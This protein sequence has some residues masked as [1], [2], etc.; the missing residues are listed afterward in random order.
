MKIKINK[1]LN[2]SYDERPKIIAEISGNHGGSKKR[3]LQLIKSAALNG[4]DLIKIQ[5]YEPEDITLKSKT[6]QFYLKDGIWKGQHLWSLYENSCTPFSWHKDAFKLAKK[7]KVELF[8]SPFSIRGVDLLEKY[9]CKIYKIASFEITDL[10]LVNYIASKKKPIIMSTGMASSVEIKNAINT[11]KK[12]HNKIIILHCVSLYPTRL[13]QINLNR[14]NK[15]K[16]LY[17]KC[18]I[19]LSDHTNSI[20]SSLVSVP[21]KVVAIEKH[22]KLDKKSKTTDSDFSIIPKELNELKTLTNDIF[23]SQKNSKLTNNRENINLRRSLFAIKDIK[24]NEKITKKNIDTFR[25][26]I[27]ICA[28]KYFE[29]INR[30]TKRLIKKNKPIFYK[31]LC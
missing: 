14:I 31:D 25:P 7:L 11:I 23:L 27:G 17:R 22:F 5:T 12:Y 21:Y 4:A 28:S 1:N 20:T 15:L 29:V 16:K 18:L 2:M 6:N 10:K 24:K 19:G 8:S 13:D 9:N 26:R 30:K 3:F